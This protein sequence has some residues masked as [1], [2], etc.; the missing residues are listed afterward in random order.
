MAAN[1]FAESYRMSGVSEN[2]MHGAMGVG[3]GWK[4]P[5][6]CTFCDEIARPGYAKVKAH[7]YC[8]DPETLREKTRCLAE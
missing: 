5:F 4:A 2:E 1:F 7:E 8:E 6:L 3:K